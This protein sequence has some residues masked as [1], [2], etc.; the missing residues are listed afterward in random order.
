[1]Y[2]ST[3][4]YDCYSE[5]INT[6]IPERYFSIDV[7]FGFL[8]PAKFP[9][10][11]DGRYLI[12]VYTVLNKGKYVREYM[13]SLEDAEPRY[14]YGSDKLPEDIRDIVIN[15]II[16]NYYKAIEAINEYCKAEVIDPNRSIPDYSKL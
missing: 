9:D 4:E 8:V 11:Y 14:I 6:N 16:N 7:L 15:S 5:C 12:N 13:I 3:C 10:A 2:D 1:M